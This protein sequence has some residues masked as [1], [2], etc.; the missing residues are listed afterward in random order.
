MHDVSAVLYTRGDQDL[1]DRAAAAVLN[2]RKPRSTNARDRWLV[3]TKELVNFAIDN[4]FTIASSYGTLPYCIVS[5]M[6]KGFPTIV[7]CDNILPFMGSA[8]RQE[9]FVDSFGDLWDPESTLFVS[10]FSVGKLP[11]VA[12]RSAERDHVVAALSSLILVADIRRAGNMEAVL[13]TA[14]ARN[15]EILGMTDEGARTSGDRGTLLAPLRRR[16]FDETL[17][18]DRAERAGE[19]TPRAPETPCGPYVGTSRRGQVSREGSVATF[20]LVRDGS[21]RSVSPSISLDSS[22][23]VHYTRSCPGPW[24][25]QSMAE[26]CRS[27]VAGWENSAHTA[28]DTLNR[29]LAERLIRGSNA[30]TRGPGRVVSFTECLPEELYRLIKWQRGLIRWS[31]EPYGVAVRKEVLVTLGA[32]QVIYGP[33][34]VFD[35]LHE[36][37]TYRFQLIKPMGR[38][39]SQEKEWRLPGDLNLDD[40]PREDTVV[41]VSCSHEAGIIQDQFD[42]P[43]TW[44]NLTT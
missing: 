26:Y 43:V 23:L 15:V 4:G 9:K 39:W 41:V 31:F 44:A 3:K 42:Y 1:L 27:L 7:A 28:F 10:S 16:P 22:F 33:E 21:V 34:E 17:P 12:F 14:L 2:S 20:P 36:D 37:E 24:P 29:I 19:S 11:P 35:Q 40:V 25:G 32:A 18:H 6:A 8:G 38:D 5:W 13:Q 30:L